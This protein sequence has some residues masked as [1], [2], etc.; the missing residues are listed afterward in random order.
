MK[1]KV[2]KDEVLKKLV[3]PE[4]PAFFLPDFIELE[5][6]PVEEKCKCR[7]LENGQIIM[8]DM[9]GNCEKC[10]RPI[11]IFPNKKYPEPKKI[12]KVELSN[13]FVPGSIEEKFF[14]FLVKI[15][16]L[17]EAYNTLLANK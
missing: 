11:S 14:P 13:M 5:G 10:G 6:E 1:I 2:S 15:N 4:P 12:K 9:D 17:V 3:N 16:E 7:S 8:T